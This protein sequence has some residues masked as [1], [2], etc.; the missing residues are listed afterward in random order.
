VEDLIIE[1]E[2]AEEQAH[3]LQEAMRELPD[4]QREALYLRYYQDMDYRDICAI[5]DINY[6]SVRN[7][8][9]SAIRSLRRIL[10]LCFFWI[11]FI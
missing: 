1:S 7:L 11:F 9:A 2:M 6:Q 4:R 8:V 10:R 3:Q 5:M